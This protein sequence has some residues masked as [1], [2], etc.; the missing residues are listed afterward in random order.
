MTVLVIGAVSSVLGILYALMENDIKRLLAYSSVENIGIILLGTGASMVFSSYDMT[1][2][3]SLGLAA[4]LYHTLNHAVFKGLLFL[5]SGSIVHAMRTKN[6]EKMGGLIKRMPWTAFFFLVGS[7]AICALPPFNGFMSEWF[8][9]Q[10]L[11]MGI[12]PPAA[13]INMIM[14]LSGAALALTGA[15][16]AACFVKAFGIT[17]L[18]LPRSRDA[19]KACESP[20]SMRAGMALLAALCLV[21]GIAPAFVVGRIGDI[22]LPAL[23]GADLLAQGDSVLAGTVAAPEGFSAA[24][25]MLVALIMAGVLIVV[26]FALRLFFGRGRATVGDA[27]DCGLGRLTPRMQYSATAFTHPIR[28][29]FQRLYRPTRESRISYYVKPL[30]VKSL[31]YQSAIRPVFERLLYQP[32]VRAMHWISG[33]IQLLQSG[34]L[35]LYLGYILATLVVLLLVWR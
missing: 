33:R 19:E 28:V 11:V 26:M 25:P 5:G 16:A 24:S 34:S 15:L 14:I 30:F 17:F 35:H 20:A 10:A 3:A 7:V 31:R 21:L 23:S 12:K 1:A 8:T 32:V 18:G 22:G 13:S 4:A 9:F 2:L 29:I 27:W 6:I